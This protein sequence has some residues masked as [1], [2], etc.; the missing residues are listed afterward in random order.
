MNL[1]EDIH[2][3]KEVMGIISEVKSSYTVNQIKKGLNKSAND[4][5]ITINTNVDNV[6]DNI[7][8]FEFQV[9]SVESFLNDE[10]S[11]TS[12]ALVDNL[13][14]YVKEK[15]LNVDISKLVEYNNFR[16]EINKN[17]EKIFNLLY[18]SY[19]GVDTSNEL[20]KLYDRNN[21]L[22]KYLELLKQETLNIKQ[23]IKS[24]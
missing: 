8:Q 19:D 16:K 9:G 24:L 15:G 6:I 3:I 20:E 4:N 7:D 1:H 14:T 18:N 21:E 11:F 10:N 23:K 13:I 2:R 17:E 12:E 5:D 22:Y